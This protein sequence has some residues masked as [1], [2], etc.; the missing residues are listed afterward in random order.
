MSR[1]VLLRIMLQV[2]VLSDGGTIIIKEHFFGYKVGVSM[3]RAYSFP[4]WQMITL[5]AK[6]RHHKGGCY[7]EIGI[8]AHK[9]YEIGT[10]RA[11]VVV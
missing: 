6:K 11:Y 4:G 7:N 1:R 9:N 3:T 10:G 8:C 5:V 2:L